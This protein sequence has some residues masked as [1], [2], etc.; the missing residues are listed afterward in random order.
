MVTN[1]LFFYKKIMLL[2]LVTIFCGLLNIFL[3][4]FLIDDFVIVG[5][6]RSGVF[7][8]QRDE[9]IKIAD[10]KTNDK[11]GVF[12]QIFQNDKGIVLV[13]Q[14]KIIQLDKLGNRVV[15]IVEPE[16]KDLATIFYV[17]QTS[18]GYLIANQKGITVCDE[19]FE[20]MQLIQ[21]NRSAC[22]TMILPYKKAM[23]AL[24]WKVTSII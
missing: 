6:S 12:V 1:Y 5:T 15:R 10:H 4:L 19:N 17:Y 20:N 2:S 18:T 16:K 7:K 22:F 13:E 21:T 14:F 23:L 11:P 9:L 24:L 8:I 3:V